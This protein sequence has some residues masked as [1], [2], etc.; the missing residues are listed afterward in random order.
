VKYGRIKGE[1]WEDKGII[2]EIG[3]RQVD[4]RL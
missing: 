4:L 1:I 2:G 3:E